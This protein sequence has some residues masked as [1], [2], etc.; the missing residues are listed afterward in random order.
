MLSI[1]R[2]LIKRIFD[3][4]QRIMVN[5]ILGAEYF[6]HK[7]TEKLRGVGKYSKNAENT[8]LS[9]EKLFKKTKVK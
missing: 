3:R 4:D 9:L 7:N 6:R 2:W 8:L 5:D 1:K